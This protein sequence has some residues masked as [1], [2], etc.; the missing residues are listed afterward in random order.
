MKK[1]LLLWGLLGLSVAAFAQK[2]PTIAEKTAGLAR[3]DGFF[4]FWW[5]A[6]QGKVWLEIDRFDTEVL[7]INSL[8][9]G[10]GSNDIGLDRAQL[11]D[12]RVVMFSRVGKKVLMV[13][14]NLRYRALSQDPNE[15]RAVRESFAQSVLWGFVVEAEE[16]SKVLVDATDFLLRDAHGVAARLRGLRQGSYQ[17]NAGRSAIYL[18]RTKNFPQNTEFEATVTFTGGEDAGNYVTSVTPSAEAITLRMHHSLVQLPD[19]DYR[20]RAF[21]PRSSYINISYFDYATPVSEPIDKKFIIRH[22]L[23]KKDPTAKL[24]EPVEPIVYYLD[25]GTPEPIRSALLEGASW[26]NEAFEAAGYKN[27]FQVKLLPEGADPMDV[28]YNTITWVHRSTRGWSYGSSVVDPRTGEIIKGHVSLGSL[29]VRQD[30]LIFAGLLAPFES[31]RAVSEPM[32]KTALQRLKQLS[33]HEVGHTLGL[34]HNYAASTNGRA[35]V[36]DYPHPTIRLDKNGNIDLADAYAVGMGEWDK[37]SIAWGYQDF[38]PGT[39]E[40]KELAK[41]IDGANRRGLRFI[42]DQ[43]SRAPGGAHP[44][45]HLWDNGPDAVAELQNVLAIRQKALDNFGEKNVRPGDPMALLEDALVPVYN[46]HR[47]QVEAVAKLVGGLDYNYALR[48]DGQLVTQILPKEAQQRALAAL[49][50]AISPQTLTLSERVIGLIPPRPLGFGFTRELF[51]KRTG[52]TFDPLAAAE[53]AADLPLGLLLH[54]ERANRLVEYEARANSLGL[55]EV[56]AQLVGA[57]WK[58]ARAQ[59]L[60]RQVQFQTEQIA[61]THLLALSVN[62]NA[63]YQTRAVCQQALRELKSFIE[64]AKA[65]AD[66]PYLAHLDLALERMKAPEKAKVPGHKEM[67]PGAPIGTC[68]SELCAGE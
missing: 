7:Y 39:D 58:S 59:G 18:P 21:D 62:E 33:A 22:R 34:V 60:A 23:K 16:G 30:Y 68:E 57:T 5:D 2:L 56:L 1:I 13:Q 48:G 29:R 45:S 40:A 25:N 50:G 19:A 11:G 61:L 17:L 67:P 36:M 53:A 52:L 47:Y 64:S 38:P 31:G 14:P 41:L 42:S 43:D 24:S 26:W 66:A 9:G 49:L 3:Q 27:A 55:A 6:A 46:Y 10:L 28:R 37:V 44:T 65:G 12:E 4:P 51:K 54:P 8:P 20:P 35:S 63:T 15:R 32:L